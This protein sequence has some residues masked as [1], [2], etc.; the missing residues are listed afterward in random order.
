MPPLQ[1]FF[2]VVLNL[3]SA[4]RAT[5]LFLQEFGRAL[6]D[7]AFDL[8]FR[9]DLEIVGEKGT[10]RIPRAWLPDEEALLVIDDH[11]KRMP[12]SNQY[13]SEFAHL[14][15]C[16]REGRPPRYGPD[17]AVRQMRAVDAVLR[18][19]RTGAPEPVV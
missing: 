14:S 7:C 11:A 1:V 2:L 5:A 8:P 4:V 17:D 10:I 3:W 19:I 16:V 9:N 18:S 13:V 6:I 15:R 12:P